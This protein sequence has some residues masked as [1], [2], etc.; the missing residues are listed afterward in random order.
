MLIYWI[1][2]CSDTDE[3]YWINTCEIAT[4]NQSKIFHSSSIIHLIAYSKFLIRK[5][6]EDRL[7]KWSSTKKW[8]SSLKMWSFSLPSEKSYAT[9]IL[10]KYIGDIDLLS[11]KS[12]FS[13]PIFIDSLIIN[14]LKKFP[15]YC[16][17][18]KLLVNIITL[19]KW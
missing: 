12:N 14:F 8:A 10:N 2:G 3:Q 13:I 7:N 9:S 5:L 15:S 1:L 4:K 18:N 16:K 6:K 19:T 17:K 11:Q